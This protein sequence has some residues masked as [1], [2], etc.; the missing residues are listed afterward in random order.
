MKHL[1]R[2]H[3]TLV[4]GRPGPNLIPWN[5]SELRAGGIQAILSVNDGELV[6]GDDL[7]AA[8]IDYV[9]APLSDAAPPRQGDLDICLASL[10]KGFEFVSAHCGQGRKTLVHCRQGRDRTGMF[11]A[12]YMHKQF[13][14]S[15][16]EAVTR[17]QQVRGDALAAEGWKAFT[18]RVLR[19]S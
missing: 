10:S 15:P 16:E 19:A 13:C 8:G 5:P 18:I 7:L 4:F 3:D 9:C 14:V 1:Y 17:L 6:H 12:Y 2:L 11:L